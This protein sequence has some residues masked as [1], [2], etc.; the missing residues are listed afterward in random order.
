VPD[1]W[2]RSPAWEDEARAD[3]ETRLSRAR[4][5]SRQQYLFIKAAQLRSAGDFQTAREL[6]QRVIDEPDGFLHVVVS[7]WQVLAE[8]AVEQGDR[9]TAVDLYRRILTA[10]PDG[11]GTD[12]NVEIAL[13][14]LLLDSD[15]VQ[16]WTEAGELL[17]AWA[18]KQG[19]KFNR[20]QFRWH[21]AAIRVGQVFD[22]H[23]V[24]RRSAVAA[25][26]LAASGPQL[27]RHKDVGLVQTDQATLER[28]W[29]LAKSGNAG[30]P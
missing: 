1:E 5:T 14:E 30:C 4:K 20:S 13:A 16:D 7:A 24:V 12:G 11:S 23:D 6:L 21:L 25:L 10:S 15:S 17:N 9:S 8:L 22:D 27:P 19:T 18:T 28:L 29:K 2:Y 26:D 3:F